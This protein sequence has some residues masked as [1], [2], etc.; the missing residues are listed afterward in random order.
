VLIL[1]RNSASGFLNALTVAPITTTVRDIPSEVLLSPEDALLTD[2]AADMDNIQTVPKHK[3]GSL[4]ASLPSERMGE[5]NRA[6]AFA[7]DLDVPTF[8][9]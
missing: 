4:I 7:L 6:I 3:L 5:V 2:Y 8:G 1:T 9:L